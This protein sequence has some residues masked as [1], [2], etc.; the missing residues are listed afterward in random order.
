MT[1]SPELLIVGLTVFNL[2]YLFFVLAL[3]D[4]FFS[5]RQHFGDPSSALPVSIIIP[6]KGKDDGMFENFVALCRQDYPCTQVIFVVGEPHDPAIPVLDQVIRDCPSSDILLVISSQ[7]IGTNEKVSNLEAGYQRARYDHLVFIDSDIRVGQDYLRKIIPPLADHRIGLVTCLPYYRDSRNVPA[8]L[9]TVGVNSNILSMYI[10]MF[11]LGRMNYG[12]GAT[13][14]IRRSM[15]EALGGFS[16]VADAVA[17]DAA[18]GQL[19]R[20]RGYTIYLSPYILHTI[21]HEDSWGGYFYHTL[22]WSRT[23]RSVAPVAYTSFVFFFGTFYSFLYWIL[24][25]RNIWAFLF[26]V[27]VSF[28]RIVMTAYYNDTSIKDPSTQQYLWLVPV[29]DLLIPLEWLL[30]FTGQTIRWRGNRYRIQ[31]GAR[32]Q[33]IA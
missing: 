17:D 15:L 28:T 14:A 5:R 16:K 4:Y 27:F 2:L 18:I 6:V 8:A 9:E 26:F 7:K 3:T 19:V 22:R 31:S 12:T 24:N 23:I 29:R 1:P 32:I 25:L 33:R 11:L 10:P 21:H 13:L 30:G 20:K